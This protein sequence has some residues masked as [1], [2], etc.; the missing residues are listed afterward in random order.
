MSRYD[1]PASR[2]SSRDRALARTAH[3]AAIRGT[4]EALEA[5]G[6]HL[7]TLRAA[8][9]PAAAPATDNTNLWVPVGP[10][11]VVG[12]QA[13]GRPRVS[14]RIRDLAVSPDGQRVYAASAVGGVWYSG[15]A[16]A[17]WTPVGAWTSA[18][19]AEITSPADPLVCGCLLVTFGATDADDDVLVGT[20]ETTPS[21][22]SGLPGK[23]LGGVG[24]L[25]AHGPVDAARHD[26]LGNPWQRTAKNLRGLGIYRLV[27]DPGNPSTVVAAASRGLYTWTGPLV[28]N[29]DWN[30]VTASPFDAATLDPDEGEFAVTDL[31]WTP[32]RSAPPVSGRLWVAVNDRRT[33]LFT[34]DHS[35]LFVSESGVAGPFHEVSLSDREGNS[36]L[37]IATTSD[38]R[39]LYVLG[40]AARLWRVDAPG[41]V[42]AVNAHR[43]D[44]VPG[45]MFGTKDEDQ[46]H[47][48]LMVAADP[49]R[50]DRI[51]IGGAATAGN[52][53]LFRCDVTGTAPSYRLS[54]A[55]PDDKADTDPTF[56]GEGVHADVHACAWLAV[57]GVRQMWIGCDGGVYRSRADGDRGTFVPRN[58][59]LA[60]LEAGFVASHPT[61]DLKIIAGTQ[62]NGVLERV[63][64]TV[65]NRA[66]GGDGGGVAYNPLSPE[67]F[68]GQYTFATWRSE[69][70]VHYPIVQRSSGGPNKRTDS[71]KTEYD[72]SSFYSGVAVTVKPTPGGDVVRVALG[73]HRVW[74]SES[75]P[76]APATWNSTWVTLPSAVDPRR[77]S[78]PGATDFR[79]NWSDD[80]PF[81]SWYKSAPEPDAIVIALRWATPDRLLVLCRGAV[82]LLDYDAARTPRWQQTL[83]DRYSEPSCGR[84]NPAEVTDVA[85]HMMPIGR[86]SD[87]ASH[88]SDRGT[89]GSFYVVGSGPM[90]GEDLATTP[91]A[92]SVWWYDGTSKWHA[93]GLRAA[94][95]GVPAPAYAVAVHPWNN[96]IVFVGT[97]VGVWRG[98]F[99]DGPDRPNWTWTPFVNGL[100][101]AAV[102]DLSFFERR[103]SPSLLL[104]RAALQARGVWEVDLTG[105]QEPRTYLRLE[106]IDS[107]RVA[108]PPPPPAPAPQPTWDASPDVRIRPALGAPIPAVAAAGLPWTIGAPTRH[109]LWAFQT[110]LHAVDPLCRA[111]GNWT[112]E[113]VKR[114]KAR[115][116]TLS[117]PP[118]AGQVVDAVLWTNVMTAAN[119]FT[120]PWVDGPGASALA[121]Q[122]TE[123]DLYELVPDRPALGNA[124]SGIAAGKVKVDVLVHHRHAVEVSPDKV[125]VT[126]AW[127][128][129][130]AS[131]VDWPTMP[132]PWAPAVQQML[133]TGGAS[134]P[135][136]V[137]A[138][139]AIGDTARFTRQPAGPLDARTP[140]SVTFDLDFSSRTT[141]TALIL[142]AVVHS[143]P[144]PVTLTGTTLRDLVLNNHQVG[145]RSIEII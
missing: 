77:P 40:R 23:Q 50:T 129:L 56:I 25:Y 102:Q 12:G 48:D 24:I 111:D 105:P 69:N 62:D 53:S 110:A 128:P 4:A 99:D 63:G 75:A 39:V 54:F 31:A 55:A 30:K 86:W 138:P 85:D 65:W 117:P 44:Q 140:R 64:D 66:L 83:I 38:Q 89:R 20:G 61:S 21:P 15:D 13:S 139:W 119:V 106:Q 145:A 101:E 51:V 141:G 70:D 136:P 94:R 47:Y 95:D 42:G 81:D 143:D 97:A 16:G 121:R 88:S 3:L 133:R 96:D 144:D 73:T 17:S 134:F 113:F 11:T 29:G 26:P 131:F 112:D 35:G 9:A 57:G 120:E 19:R 7:R 100:P 18:V 93:T 5:A 46:S 114:C 2:G 80:T 130:P 123:A 76:G 108:P 124:R 104:L 126:L 135:G 92:D 1:W 43:V 90:R 6:L 107:R 74:L 45:L 22:A 137:P 36:R 14:G 79:Q 98:E 72:G 28:E 60:V 125:L 10:S 122:P 67:H 68:M 32:Q 127:A 49:V 8:S 103:T 37:G 34:A 91:H 71:E 41:D 84:A 132:V 27:R 33:G 58:T 59:G 118:A 82:F 115:R 116:A 78:R 52:A 87:I 142:V 109:L